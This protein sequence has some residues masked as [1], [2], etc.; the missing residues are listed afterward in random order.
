MIGGSG[1]KEA[2]TET[3]YDDPQSPPDYN[4]IDGFAAQQIGSMAAKAGG[5]KYKGKKYKGKKFTSKKSKGKKSKAKKTKTKKNKGKA[6]A[7]ILHVKS[8]AKSRG[9]NFPEA[10]KHPDCK[11]TYK[12]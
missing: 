1:I 2:L 8:F 11:K 6:G 5:K 9:L 10:L 3:P 4:N 12:K 7:W